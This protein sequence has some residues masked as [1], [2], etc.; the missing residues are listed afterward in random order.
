[1]I[2]MPNERGKIQLFR[3][4]LDIENSTQIQHKFKLMAALTICVDRKRKRKDGLY[5]VYIRVTHYGRTA[6]IKTDKVV[7]DKCLSSSWEIIDPFVLKPLSAQVVEWLDRLNRHNISTW[8][9]RQLVDFLKSTD[10]ELIFSDYARQYIDR[11]I[12]A[13]QVRNA[14]NYM[15]ALRSLEL[16]MCTNRICFSQMTSTTINR[17]IKSLEATAR[18]KEM[19]PVCI[20]QIFRGALLEYNDHDAGIIRIKSNPWPKVQIPH[21]DRPEKKAITAEACRAFFAAPLPPSNMVNPKAE[22]GRDV[23]MLILCLAGINTVDLF[24]LRKKD[25]YGGILHYRR[26]KTTKCRSDDGYFEIRVPEVVKSLL[27]KY[28]A[29]D[30]SQAL[31]SFC[32]RYR[33]ADSFNANVNG[34]L[35]IFAAQWDWPMKISIRPTHSAIHGRRL[36][37]MIAVRRLMKLALG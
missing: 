24:Q 12:D 21:A 22:I 20:R 26:S 30:D 3:G 34:A 8:T 7:S 36:R 28:K 5:Q 2:L 25:Y 37:R 16:H 11:M 19:Y 9:A 35:R 4:I 10:E 31:F 15:L 6:Y 18:A 32:E 23:A 29:S 33:N 1:M 27:E 17:W 13:G 14:K